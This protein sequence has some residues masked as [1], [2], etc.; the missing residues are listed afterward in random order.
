[1]GHNNAETTMTYLHVMQRP[2]AA[3]PSPLDLA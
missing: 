2:G 3:G 1:M